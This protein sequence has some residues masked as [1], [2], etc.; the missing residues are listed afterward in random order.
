VARFSRCPLPDPNPKS[1]PDAFRFAPRPNTSGIAVGP[2][3]GR[4]VMMDTR[5][6]L[7]VP[8]EFCEVSRSFGDGARRVEA[9]VG[10]SFSLAVGEFV[11]V[12]GPSGSGKSTLLTIAGGLEQPSAGTVLVDGVDL[13]SLSASK[14][15]EIRLRRVGY[16]FQEFNLLPVE[17][18]SMPLELA[19]EKRGQALERAADQLDAVG[20]SERLH[21]FPDDL[22]GGEQQ[23]VAIARALATGGR[24]ILADEPTGALDSVT[25]DNV[26]RAL[27]Q[28]CDRGASAVVVTHN[29]QLAA[30]ADRVIFL[31]DGRIV[32]QTEP[33]TATAVSRRS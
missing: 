13:G 20:L 5:N 16:V 7:C 30:W 10:V 23:R 22:S 2:G 24:L 6:G 21:H 12:M 1:E 9:L 14:L 15:A 19:G 28:T 26:M 4:L 8:L 17:N 3:A 18:V 32:D 29:A 11:A 33:A 25:G 31:R 27:R